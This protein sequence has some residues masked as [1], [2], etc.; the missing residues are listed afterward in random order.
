M[1]FEGLGES[2]RRA[3]HGYAK[4]CALCH[5]AIVLSGPRP[6]TL[7]LALIIS[8]SLSL[9][10]TGTAGTSTLPVNGADHCR[11]LDPAIYIYNTEPNNANWIL[12]QPSPSQRAVPKPEPYPYSPGRNTWSC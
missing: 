1:L 4:A 10:S 12:A 5:R 7:T 11:H 8:A 9:I 3:L 2:V 6:P